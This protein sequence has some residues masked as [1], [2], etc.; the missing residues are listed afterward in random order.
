MKNIEKNIKKPSTKP[1]LSPDMASKR[2]AALAQ[3]IHLVRCAVLE[4]L[5][6]LVGVV[7]H[8]LG[9]LHTP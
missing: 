3:V 7:G 8:A 2:G 4:L 1:Y 6:G 5:E 9:L